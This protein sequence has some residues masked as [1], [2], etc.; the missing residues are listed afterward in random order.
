MRVSIHRSDQGS[1][2]VNY[3][4]CEGDTLFIHLALPWT[5]DLPNGHFND[6]ICS[7][8]KNLMSKMKYIVPF[9]SSQPFIIPLVILRKNLMGFSFPYLRLLTCPMAI[10]M[11]IYACF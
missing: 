5:F 6:N 11:I 4:D 2:L 3:L 1:F 10:L 7:F 8:L 9:L